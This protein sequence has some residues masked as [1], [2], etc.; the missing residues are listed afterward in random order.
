MR[1]SGPLLAVHGHC[2]LSLEG[3]GA[4]ACEARGDA[5]GDATF[6]FTADAT[7]TCTADASREEPWEATREPLRSPWREPLSEGWNEGSAE[8][9]REAAAREAFREA[10]SKGLMVGKSEAWREGLR[11]ALREVA[12]EA[13]SDLLMAREREGESVGR[14]AA[15]NAVCPGCEMAGRSPLLHE[16]ATSAVEGSHC[17]SICRRGENNGPATALGRSPRSRRSI[18][19]EQPLPIEA[20]WWASIVGPMPASR[21]LS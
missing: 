14:A 8:A 11:E 13:S 4:E 18:A 12:S 15:V 3:L 2:P 5:H 17:A 1:G 21:G 20:P 16:D 7:F 9:T 10:W 19:D 6:T